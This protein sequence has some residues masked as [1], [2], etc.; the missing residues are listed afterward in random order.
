ME[1]MSG[2]CFAQLMPSGGYELTGDFN[3]INASVTQLD[4]PRGL[5]GSTVETDDTNAPSVDRLLLAT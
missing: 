4:S 2:R 5:S 1:D 3:S